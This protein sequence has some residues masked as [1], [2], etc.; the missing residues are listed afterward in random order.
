MYVIKDDDDY[1][2]TKIWLKRFIKT[3]RNI[4]K[5]YSNDKNKLALLDSGYI[6]QIKDFIKQLR[7]Y[8]RKQKMNKNKVII[9][10]DDEGLHPMIYENEC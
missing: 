3:V 1:K 8:R 9:C 4:R 6:T 5:R 7:I 2:S 10:E